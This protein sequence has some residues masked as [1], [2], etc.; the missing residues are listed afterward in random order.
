MHEENLIT[1]E[2]TQ[3]PIVIRS[4]GLSV[5]A[6]ELFD[7]IAKRAHEIYESKGRVRE[8]DLDNWLQ[9]ETELFGQTLVSVKDSPESLTV[10]ADMRN[11]TPKELEIDLQPERVT[12]IAKH[13]NQKELRTATD[14]RKEESSS[15]LVRS[16]QLPVKIDA[17][18]ASARL[19][20]GILEL[21]LKKATA[22]KVKRAQASG[23]AD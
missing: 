17:R 20:N 9:A 6:K 8:H 21:D 23:H 7:A 12:I 10:L 2:T 14:I 5:E 3:P 11:F 19:N 22:A 15:R 18:H 13:Q 1:N 4:R 16:L